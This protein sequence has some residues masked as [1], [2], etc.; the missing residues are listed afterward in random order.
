MS[1]YAHLDLTRPPAPSPFH[2]RANAACP[3]YM[4]P[5]PAPGGRRIPQARDRPEISS[6]VDEEHNPFHETC[7]TDDSNHANFNDTCVKLRLPELCRSSIA[8]R[9]VLFFV[10]AR[11]GVTVKLTTLSDHRR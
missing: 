2:C 1:R 11:G 9:L 10:V 6:H 7:H 5:A 4:T 3:W 8:Y